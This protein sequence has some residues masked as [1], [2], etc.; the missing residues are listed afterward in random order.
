MMKK[1]GDEIKS[2][3][4]YKLPAGPRE[5]VVRPEE[6]DI[7]MNEEEQGRYRSGVGMLLW[8]SKHSRPDIANAVREASKVMDSGTKV[9]YQYLLR[10]IKYTVETGH[11]KLRLKVNSDCEEKWKLI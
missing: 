9:H 10:L 5:Q 8:L 3:K 2:M 4:N 6:D 1:F 7:K 11:Q